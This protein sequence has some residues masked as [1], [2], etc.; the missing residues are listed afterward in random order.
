[1]YLIIDRQEFIIPKQ[2]QFTQVPIGEPSSDLNGGGKR[3][4][5]YIRLDLIIPPVSIFT[6][7]LTTDPTIP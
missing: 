2:G 4:V 3:V 7:Q 6:L 5:L 1:M